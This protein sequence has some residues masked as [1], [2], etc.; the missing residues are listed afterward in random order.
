DKFP[1]EYKSFRNDGSDYQV[2]DGESFR[3]FYERCSRALEEVSFRHSGK[4]I[5]LVTHGGFLGAIFRYVLKIPLDAERN[6]VLLNCSVNRLEKTDKGWNLIS[7]GD[8]AHL[9]GLDS[10]DDA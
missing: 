3:Q 2:P 4:R 1:K 10:L 5:G 6:Y 8:V 9:D 7:W